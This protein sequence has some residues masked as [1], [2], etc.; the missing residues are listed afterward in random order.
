MKQAYPGFSQLVKTSIDAAGPRPLTP[1]Y[2]DV[3]LGIQDALQP[4]DK[5]DPNDVTPAYDSVKSNVDD[6]VA[7]KGLL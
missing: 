3:S 7:G 5:I 2:Q 6:A 1:A 4:P